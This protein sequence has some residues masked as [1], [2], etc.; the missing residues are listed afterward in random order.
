MKLLCGYSSSTY[1]TKSNHV[2]TILSWRENNL[3]L[4]NL[5]LYHHVV[6]GLRSMSNDHCIRSSCRDQE[7]AVSM[8]FM[9]LY[10]NLCLVT[11]SRHLT[12]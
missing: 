2:F 6:E 9:S 1:G 7:P 4:D 8:A 11:S 5:P 3:S 12:S 10:S